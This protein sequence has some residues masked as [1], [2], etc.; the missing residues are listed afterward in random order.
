MPSETLSNP[1]S[2][3]FLT[4]HRD[5]KSYILSLSYVPIAICVLA[6]ARSAWYRITVTPDECRSFGWFSSSSGEFQCDHKPL[7]WHASLALGWLATFA[8]QVAFLTANKNPW[9]KTFGKFIGMAIAFGNAIGM[10]YLAIYDSIHPMAKTDRPDDFT[11]F[12]FLVAC[13]FSISLGLATKAIVSKERNVEQHMLWMYRAFITSFTTPVIRF[14]PA[15]LRHLA[16]TDCFQE[17]R[18]K[19][20]MGA[21]FVSELV[22]VILYTLVQ[23]KTQTKFWDIFMKLQVLTFV[24]AFLKEV[25]FASIHGVFLLGMAECF[26]KKIEDSYISTS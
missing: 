13:K 1:T 24:F 16:G 6:F 22:C 7:D 20:V 5:R 3:C 17:H 21:M 26:T 15:I 9:H 10:F 25:R 14:Y 8:L 18:E 23:L 11:P 4:K 2:S 12:M 19:F